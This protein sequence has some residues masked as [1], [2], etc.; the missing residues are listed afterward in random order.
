MCPPT[1]S[2]NKLNI[3]E[4]RAGCVHGALHRRRIEWLLQ[5][6]LVENAPSV[7]IER[8]N[9]IRKRPGCKR[10]IRWSR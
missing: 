3:C 5:L 2:S 8:F 10:T 1:L 9:S 6:T 4:E 7:S